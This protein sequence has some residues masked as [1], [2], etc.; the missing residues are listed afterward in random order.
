MLSSRTGTARRGGRAMADTRMQRWGGRLRLAMG[1]GLV[2]GVA[3]LF[4]C[5][6]D[7][8]GHVLGGPSGDKLL[9]AAAMLGDEQGVAAALRAG[10]DVNSSS[11]DGSTALNWAAESG[12]SACVRRLVEAGAKVDVGH[13]GQTPLVQAARHDHSDAIEML[14][15][16][17]ADPNSGQEM[18]SPLM[19]AASQASVGA[20][21]TLLAAG[22]DVNGKGIG[23]VT[24]LMMAAG[25]DC[26]R[27]RDAVALLLSRGA[28]P[29]ATDDNGWTAVD[30]AID[31]R[32]PELVPLIRDA[33]RATCDSPR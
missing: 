27:S 18:W 14:I 24:P 3:R 17:G 6:G 7:P 12:S 2:V 5:T 8:L 13:N 33:Q 22:A 28:D 23:G 16:A 31:A 20:A 9:V 11:E 32:H 10:A 30:Y 1:I 25:S 21:K 29:A 19:S 4:V 15:D 26:E